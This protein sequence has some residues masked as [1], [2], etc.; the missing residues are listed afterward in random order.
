ML[1]TA[2]KLLQKIEE[3]GYKAYIV[4]GFVRNH[5][6]GIESNDIDIATSAT[7]MDIK[8]IFKGAALPNEDY[9]SITV[10]IKNI[11]FE[12]TTFRRELT[13]YNNRKPIEIEYIDDLLEDLKRRDFTINTL[14]MNHKG[15]ILDLLSGKQDIFEHKIKTVGDSY[16]K[17]SEDTL[18]ILRAVRFATI[19]DF[20]LCDEVKEAIKKT[21]HL[22]KGLSYERK[23][24]ELDKIFTNK[25]VKK[26]VL[27]LQ[28]LELDKELEIENISK[29]K[30]YDDLIGIW[31]MLD[32][33]EKYHFTSNEKELIKKIK[34][35]LP[36]D[37]LNPIVLYQYGL[38][39]NS[40]VASQKEI[41]K[42]QI[43]KAYNELP[44]YSRS[45]IKVTGEDIIKAINQKQGPILREIYQD[46]T[47]KILT[48]KLKNDKKHLLNYC[49]ENYKEI[50]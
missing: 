42:K 11:R 7:P 16:Q 49:I 47:I 23:R 20:S 18:R 30:N 37:N 45:D 19:L 31:S 33:E 13:Y 43:T 36:L 12:I 28:E 34:E 50:D 21:K 29:V 35:A 22:L 40:V 6:L 1:K 8:A 46:L 4:G 38:Y 15:E 26:G 17:F 27:L 39:V 48:G 3:H 32:V 44:I 14:C 25:N 2:L 41:D 10:M 5:I 9:G 24:E